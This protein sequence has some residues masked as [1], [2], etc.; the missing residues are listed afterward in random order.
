[1]TPRYLTRR[2]R[3]LAAL[4][5]LVA[6]L[7]TTAVVLFAGSGGAQE[8]PATTVGISAQPV[9]AS[10]VSQADVAMS[11]I[12]QATAG[13]LASA[14]PQA[15]PF[16]S[17]LG[18]NLATAKANVAAAP[19]A[20]E[21]FPAAPSGASQ[22]I[23]E[24]NTPG[25]ALVGWNSMSNS[26]TI[27][28]YFGTGCQPPDDGIASNGSYVL[29]VVNTSIA[30]YSSSGAIQAGF[31]KSL[32]TF[33][34]VP[35]PTPA[36][37][38][39]AHNN[40]PFLTDPRAAWDPVT[41]RWYVAMLQVEHAFGL[42]PSCTF[43]SKYWVAVSATTSPTGSWHI[44]SFNT[45]NL[46]GGGN[47]A[48]DYTQLGFNNE[49]IFIGGN[50]FNNAG[51]AYN[52]AWTLA[53]PKG[54]AE[55]GAAISS[56]SGFGGYTASDGSATRLLDTVQPVLSYG[57]GYGGP[58][59]EF[60]VSSFNE[61]VTES[62]V[63]VFDF[64]NAKAQQSHGQ[65]ISG[66]VIPTRAYA[67]PPN[68]DNYPSCTNCLETIDNRISATPVYMGG[69]IYASHDTAVNNGTATNANVHWMIIQPVITQTSV[70]GCTLCSTITT[71]TRVLDNAYIT[72]SGTTDDWFGVVQPDREGNLF[73]AY[74]YGS[75][76]G[77][78]SPSSVYIARRATAAAGSSFGD[79]GVYLKVGSA[80][81]TN[82]RWGD[83][84]AAGYEGWIGN[85]IVFVTEWS[86]GNW[87]T[88][89]DRVGYTS[90]VQK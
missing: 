72:Y 50:Q 77:H 56:I 90:L 80:A 53:I 26:G 69:K 19:Q 86:N 36:G 73:V 46:V 8:S 74:E 17:P 20:D 84:E 44:Y 28:S 29:H 79:G 21:I 47:S 57:S 76:S 3:R 13:Q 51:T 45:G 70:S 12:P 58:A 87:S 15:M 65:T 4:L 59:G 38:D 24:P 62:K 55:S 37:C 81:T 41:G 23:S 88:H 33:F 27:C 63:V 40:H 83:Y 60:L 10:L 22:A 6:G 39:S 2:L 7:L 68:A 82:S 66:V 14:K 78:V 1:V 49:A 54:A 89:I 85:K 64:S 31:P 75:T 52:G 25:G 5:M 18:K 9:S 34:G 16:L 61:N 42:S 43:V 71:S 67:Q 32:Q 30:I 48:A 35:A 11:A